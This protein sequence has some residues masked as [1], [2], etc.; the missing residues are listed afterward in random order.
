MRTW[1]RGE[2]DAV[3]LR[4]HAEKQLQQQI[5]DALDDLPE[6]ERTVLT[7]HYLAGMTCKEIGQFIGASPGAVQSRLY[8]ARAHLK[9]EI[10]PVLRSTLGVIQ[11]PPTFTEQL[12]RQIRELQPTPASSGKPML[13]W[14]A[15]TTLA[16]IVLF[17]GFG[18]QQTTWF[19]RPY[20][21]NAPE[22]ATM[23]EI[24]DAPVVESLTSQRL[25]FVQSAS[26]NAGDA[27]NGDQIDDA[28]SRNAMDSATQTATAD[29]EW[30]P[31]NGPYGGTILSL[32]VTQEGTV[33]AGTDK[34]Y[35]FRSTNRGESWTR[36]HTP[37]DHFTGPEEVVRTDGNRRYIIRGGELCCVLDGWGRFLDCRLS[38]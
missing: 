8:R 17:I 6:S 29:G 13:P 18:Q 33:F 16:V 26:L 4:R 25:L 23:V 12:V 30:A 11:L 19:Q 35:L 32:L 9:E 14:I 5:R 31:M 10:I 24:V 2:I 21:L 38:V 28:N 36:I 3:A 37:L 7:L 20:S 15:A 27:G 1:K 34:A 22:S